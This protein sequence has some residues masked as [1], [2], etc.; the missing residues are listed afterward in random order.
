MVP[1][2]FF[3]SEPGLPARRQLAPAA[4]PASPNS[5][6]R[7]QSSIL[8]FPCSNRCTPGRLSALA[9]SLADWPADIPRVSRW[10]SS[11]AALRSADLFLP[12][13]RTLFLTPLLGTGTALSPFPE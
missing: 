2:G 10:P 9:R 8:H 3:R 7:E 13:T 4:S 12:A 5:P 11:G 1:Q 6:L